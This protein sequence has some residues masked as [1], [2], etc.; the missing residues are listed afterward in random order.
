MRLGDR[1]NVIQSGG[2]NVIH[3]GSPNLVK[4][5]TKMDTIV[6]ASGVQGFSGASGGAS[7][8]P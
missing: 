8:Q 2:R 5:M 7:T 3:W 4:C 1:G 6:L